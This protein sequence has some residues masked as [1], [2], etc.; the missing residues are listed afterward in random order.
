MRWTGQVACIGEKR[1]GYRNL[2]EKP[3]RKRPLGRPKSRWEDN[4]TMGLMGWGGGDWSD[5]AQDRD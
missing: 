4:N 5:L 2:V 3:H 1:N